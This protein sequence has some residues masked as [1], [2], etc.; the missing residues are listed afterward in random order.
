MPLPEPMIFPSADLHLL[1]GSV[2]NVTLSTQ[3]VL[4]L[5]PLST[6]P[7][8]LRPDAVVTVTDQGS[9]TTLIPPPSTPPAQISNLLKFT[10]AA[11]APGTPATPFVIATLTRSNGSITE[12]L[13]FRVTLHNS[14]ND[15]WFGNTS[16]TIQQ[17]KSNYVLSVYAQFDDGSVADITGVLGTFSTASPTIKVDAVTGRITAVTPGQAEVSVTLGIW[18]RSVPVTVVAAPTLTPTCNSPQPGAV[19]DILFLSEGF[20]KADSSYFDRLVQSCTDGLFAPSNRPFDLLRN[21]INVWQLFVPT[22]EPPTR[23]PPLR[24][25]QGVTIGPPVDPPQNES[26]QYDFLNGRLLLDARDTPFG[27]MSY[28]R[29]GT[30]RFKPAPVAPATMSDFLKLWGPNDPADY[31]KMKVD[32][33]RLPDPGA[34]TL[35]S[36]TTAQFDDFFDQLKCTNPDGSPATYTDGQ[37]KIHQLA[38][39]WKSEGRSRGLV[40]MLIYDD[41][42][43]GTSI[44]SAGV[45]ALSL[46]TSLGM[47]SELLTWAPPPPPELDHEPSGA[48][49]D[50]DALAHRVAH[51]LGHGL[52]L[53][54]EYDFGHDGSTQMTPEDIAFVESFTNLTTY[55]AS[56][57]ATAPTPS[58]ATT[59]W[60]LDRMTFACPI[61][62]DTGAPSAGG[63]SVQISAANGALWKRNVPAGANVYIR[64][65]ARVTA[66]QTPPQLK[67]AS[68]RFGPY[69]WA[70]DASNTTLTLSNSG[71][72]NSPPAALDAGAV[73][74]LPLTDAAGTILTLIPPD[75]ARWIDDH[76]AGFPRRGSPQP[77]P[78]ETTEQAKNV[79]PPAGTLYGPDTDVAEYPPDILRNLPKSSPLYR[80]QYGYPGVYTGGGTWTCGVYRPAGDCRMRDSSYHFCMVCEY[81]IV[82]AVDP[83]QL[84]AVDA[85]YPG[86]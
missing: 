36:V 59:K 74:Y 18:T 39:G 48:A 64:E 81:L 5:G 42:N 78:C 72:V 43:G 11:T 85:R 60:N 4:S 86:G 33:R 8:G 63:L 34:S 10:A 46:G 21:S 29:P 30:A 26:I 70:L 58:A 53:G 23:T 77:L 17:G 28:F 49:P 80:Y 1:P 15:I 76:Q 54:D 51:E 41:M 38:E 6:F 67:P 71:T 32:I 31:R 52:G 40:V 22:P 56:T 55:G 84:H 73:V 62:R 45:I 24:S 14:I 50:Y 57:G 47:V 83:A 61:T 13:P 7:S 44:G 12:Y 79:H 20:L 82:D 37:G 68:N 9:N 25:L 27:L 65:A 16:V 3:S 35:E 69:T 66:S 19:R 2:V 75:A